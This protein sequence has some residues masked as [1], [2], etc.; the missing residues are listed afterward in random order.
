MSE[1]KTDPVTGLPRVDPVTQ[2]RDGCVSLW[3]ATIGTV[4]FSAVC[5]GAALTIF[6]MGSSHEYLIAMAEGSSKKMG[7]PC[8]AIWFFGVMVTWINLYPL[9]YKG[10]IMGKSGNIRANQF[11]YKQATDLN[12]NQSAVILHE[13]GEIG[14]Y[15]RGN[16]SIG[17]FL[18]NAL[19]ILVTLPIGF[20]VF[21][22][23]SALLF[24][25]YSIGRMVY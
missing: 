5:F 6:F 10:Q 4:L 12:G 21:P 9:L 18:E 8:L 20:K 22:V 2:K 1:E 11:I 19:P 14:N 16:R 24:I 15:N 3:T 13:D 23:P 7:A 25:N 17:H